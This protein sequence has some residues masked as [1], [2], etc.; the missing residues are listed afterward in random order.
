[1][2]NIEKNQ[3]VTTKPINSLAKLS[4]LVLAVLAVCFVTGCRL[5]TIGG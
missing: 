4:L 2:K 3:I 5:F 1:M